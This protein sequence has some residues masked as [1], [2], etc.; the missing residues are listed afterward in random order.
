MDAEQYSYQLGVKQCRGG[1]SQR[2][3]QLRNNFGAGGLPMRRSAENGYFVLVF[4][5]RFNLMFSSRECFVEYLS[6]RKV[7]R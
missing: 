5:P 7:Y 4:F 6:P 3:N 1:C 2:P